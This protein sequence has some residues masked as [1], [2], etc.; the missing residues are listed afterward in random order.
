[1]I[2]PKKGVKFMLLRYMKNLRWVILILLLVI[3]VFIVVWL[4]VQPTPTQ[5]EFQGTFIYSHQKQPR[6]GDSLPPWSYFK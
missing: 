6:Y 1:M 3:A 4:V 2:Y 5:Q